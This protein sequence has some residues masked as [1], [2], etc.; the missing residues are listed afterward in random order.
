MQVRT[1]AH[2]MSLMSGDRQDVGRVLMLVLM[3]AQVSKGDLG[4][5][6]RLRSGSR[7]DRQPA[8]ALGLLLFG[9]DGGS[10]DRGRGTRAQRRRQGWQVSEGGNGD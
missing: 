1:E 5:D 8:S 3:L 4:S 6:A 9:L 10:G 2:V 7:L